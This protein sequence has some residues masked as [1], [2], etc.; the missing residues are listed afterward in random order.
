M[1]IKS[2]KNGY[3][4]TQRTIYGK[5]P[6]SEFYGFVLG[7]A[8]GYII[9][10][11][12]NMSG[13]MVVNHSDIAIILCIVGVGIGWWYDQKY[14]MVKDEP[15]EG[16][17]TSAEDSAGGSAAEGSAAKDTAAEDTAAE[18]TAQTEIIEGTSTQDTLKKMF[19]RNMEE[20]EQ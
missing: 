5:V 19:E 1:K 9:G 7:I 13:V 2:A 3:H 8:F 4:S 12:I 10:A 16:A 6:A 15:E 20:R 17:E 18:D 11:L 14:Y